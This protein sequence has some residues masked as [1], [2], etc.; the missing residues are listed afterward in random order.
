M[1]CIIPLIR[2][3]SSTLSPI[4][5][6]LILR[7]LDEAKLS[8]LSGLVTGINLAI[9][10]FLEKF[11]SLTFVVNRSYT[12]E[13]DLKTGFKISLVIPSGLGAFRRVKPSM[14][15]LT[16]SWLKFLSSVVSI[17]CTI[18]LWMIICVFFGVV[19]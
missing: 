16:S 14:I 18:I 12:F 11:F 6:I 8:S 5:N 15:T 3:F 4:F 1:Y 7:Y 13:Y 9:F 19:F 10:H 2:N 17:V